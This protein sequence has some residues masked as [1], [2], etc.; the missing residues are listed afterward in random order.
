[1][2]TQY[3]LSKSMSPILV[4]ALLVS[5]CSPA[6]QWDYPRAPSNV[7]AHPETTTVGARFQ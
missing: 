1:M 6:I 7:F 3:H 4:V 2:F 5:A